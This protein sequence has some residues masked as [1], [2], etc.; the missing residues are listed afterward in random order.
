MIL[1][2]SNISISGICFDV[3]QCVC[4]IIEDEIRTSLPSFF[5]REL[6]LGSKCII[7]MEGQKT[8]IFNTKVG[9][10]D[11]NLLAA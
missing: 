10:E 11:F 1:Y 8:T 7:Q 5:N 2:F 9:S 6:E 4:N 3:T